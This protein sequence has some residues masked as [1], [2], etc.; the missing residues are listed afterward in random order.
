MKAIG[1]TDKRAHDHGIEFWKAV[2]Q[3]EDP[4]DSVGRKLKKEPIT[5]IYFAKRNLDKLIPVLFRE[6]IR[7]ELCSITADDFQHTNDVALH[8]DSIISK[9]KE[10]NLS[11]PSVH[12]DTSLNTLVKEEFSR[13]ETVDCWI[14]PRE[15]IIYFSELCENYPVAIECYVLPLVIN[16]LQVQL[17]TN[18]L[19]RIKP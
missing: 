18:C 19:R 11:S 12:K 2:S 3:V 5:S 6:L 13:K 9:M 1:S 10:V 16:E 15:V 8:T 14:A 17:I 7:G 4:R